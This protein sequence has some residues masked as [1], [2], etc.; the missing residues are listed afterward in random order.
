MW[1]NPQLRIWSYLRKKSLIE[2]FIFYAVNGLK[3]I[4]RSFAEIQP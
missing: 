3:W 2:N 1:P 4:K